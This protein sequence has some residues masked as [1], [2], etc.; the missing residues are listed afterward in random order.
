MQTRQTTETGD[1]FVSLVN[2]KKLV[3]RLLPSGSPA[4]SV[5]LA[6]R[7]TLPVREA[8]AKFEVFDRLLANELA[9]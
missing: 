9:A 5:I 4:R 1:G 3:S 6:E 2:L 8:L 7:D